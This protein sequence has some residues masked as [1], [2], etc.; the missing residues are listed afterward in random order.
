MNLTSLNLCLLFLLCLV[1]FIVIFLMSKHKQQ[2]STALT[3]PLELSG[4]GETHVR[5]VLS[6]MTL[7]CLSSD[8]DNLQISF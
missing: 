2:D 6:L 4:E 8:F 3:S 5:C 1:F 7:Y